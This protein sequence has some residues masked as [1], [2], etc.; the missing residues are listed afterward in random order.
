[1]FL[2]EYMSDDK[3]KKSEVFLD[4]DGVYCVNYF[5][6]GVLLCTESYP[7]KS[8]HWAVD[9]AENYVLGIKK[10]DFGIDK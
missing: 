9:C 7:D 6:D 1:M 8:V 3:V 5:I 2:S 10:I 4:S